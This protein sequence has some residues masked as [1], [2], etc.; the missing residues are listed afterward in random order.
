LQN[1]LQTEHSSP[2]GGGDSVAAVN[3]FGLEDK[4]S[5]VSTGGGAML[6]MLE[7]LILPGIAAILGLIRAK[8]KILIDS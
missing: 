1:Q 7:G 8:T 5:Y 2:V 3:N 4:M 6:E